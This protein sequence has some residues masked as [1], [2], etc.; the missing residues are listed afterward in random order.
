MKIY[1]KITGT[2]LGIKKGDIIQVSLGIGTKYLKVSRNQDNY[3]LS[4]VFCPTLPD[5][6]TLTFLLR[7]IKSLA[8][9]SVSPFHFLHITSLL[10]SSLCLVGKGLHTAPVDL[11]PS[12]DWLRPW[13]RIA[14]SWVRDQLT[15]LFNSFPVLALGTLFRGTG[16]C[17]LHHSTERGMCE[18]I[19]TSAYAL[20]KEQPPCHYC[21]SKG[22]AKPKYKSVLKLMTQQQEPEISIWKAS[23][24]PSEWT[25]DK[26]TCGVVII[27]SF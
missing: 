24:S 25:L 20:Q 27:F 18:N 13:V 14:G 21:S 22:A 8:S 12:R 1:W 4:L 2:L 3:S 16:S 10:C 23:P 17:R 26:D 6:D 7:A 5:F 15:Q 11:N 9:V 19:W